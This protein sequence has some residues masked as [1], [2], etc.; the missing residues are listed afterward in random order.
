MQDDPLLFDYNVE[1]RVND[2]VAAAIA[3]VHLFIVHFPLLGFLCTLFTLF[4][5]IY[6]TRVG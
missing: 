1:E 5:A 6:T 2:F 4:A 3:Q